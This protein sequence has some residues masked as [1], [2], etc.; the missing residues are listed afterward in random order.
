MNVLHF[1][2]LLAGLVTLASPLAQAQAPDTLSA[3][4]R[5]G[6]ALS[7]LGAGQR[8]QIVTR[9]RKWVEGFVVATSPNLLK[10]QTER[11]V[12]DIPAANVDSVWVQGGSTG[13]GALIGLAVGGLGLGLLA[14]STG[15]SGT[16]VG[17]GLL[18]GSL[19]G[20]VIGALIG[21]AVPSWQLLRPEQPR[22]PPC[23]AALDPD[24]QGVRCRT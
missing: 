8:V 15:Q 11:S 23:P 16:P 21:S 20:A 7:R 9:Q 1:A 6:L 10:V 14:R 19:G 12:T 2:A 18:L 13:T 24:R 4:Q 3:A 17:A 22:Q 5:A